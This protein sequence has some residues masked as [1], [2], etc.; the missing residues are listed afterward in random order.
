M[1]VSQNRKLNIRMYMQVRW[2]S[3]GGG[4]CAAKFVIYQ[5][6]QIQ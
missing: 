4:G 3:W 1:Y 5:P 6:H 2:E